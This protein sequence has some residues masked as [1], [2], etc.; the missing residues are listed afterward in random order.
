MPAATEG[1]A[2]YERKVGAG[3]TAKAAFINAPPVVQACVR[4]AL[5]LQ[6][7]QAVGAKKP[8]LSSPL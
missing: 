7:N 1:L 8:N 4:A 2:E 3:V 5:G 6:L